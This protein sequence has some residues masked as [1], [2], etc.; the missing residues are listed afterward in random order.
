MNMYE[1]RNF[2]ERTKGNLIISC[3]ALPEEPLH[4]EFIMG[5][6]ALAAEQ[7]GASGIRANSVIDIQEIKRQVDVPIIGI[8]KEVYE[9]SDVF[10]TPTMKEIDALVTE[11]VDVIAIDATNRKRP[12][13][14]TITT[15]FPTIRK[16]YPEEV[17]M[18]DCSSY[19]DAV[20]ASELGFDYIGTTLHGYTT[21]TAG[22]MLPNFD[23]IAKLVK[24]IDTPIIAEGGIWSPEQL[25]EI[26]ALGVHTSVVGSV[27]TR[28]FEI[29][30]RFVAVIE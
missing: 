12:D 3:Q 28:P 23:L 9:G 11:G 10:I 22:V 25:K 8:I 1:K 7:A 6:M 19:E 20:K 15:Q 14:T 27:I 21:E 16:K 26:M 18:A 30:K 5:R 29:A 2:H 4:S 17:F 24:D 13:G